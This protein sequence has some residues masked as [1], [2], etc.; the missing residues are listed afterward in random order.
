M[1]KEMTH[2][3]PDE[4]SRSLSLG[5]QAAHPFRPPSMMPSGWAS[6][7]PQT[8]YLCRCL[9]LLADNELFRTP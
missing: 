3:P 4:G 1:A 2:I 5:A 6:R 9:E 7:I 8:A